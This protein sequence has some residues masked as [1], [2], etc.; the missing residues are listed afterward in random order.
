MGLTHSHPQAVLFIGPFPAQAV[1]LIIAAT[2]NNAVNFISHLHILQ[3][4]LHAFNPFGLTASSASGKKNGGHCDCSAADDG[5]LQP[6]FGKKAADRRP[7]NPEHQ[8]TPFARS[9]SR[10]QAV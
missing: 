5:N 6:G 9:D 2:V 8:F 3:S 4:P 1:K 10:A 7:D